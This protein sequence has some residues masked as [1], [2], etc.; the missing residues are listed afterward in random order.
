[1]SASKHTIAIAGENA[2]IIYFGDKPSAET[3]AQIAQAAEQLKMAL[4]KLLVD[5]VPSYGSL[6]V[7]YQP[8]KTDHYYVRNLIRQAL[9]KLSTEAEHNQG[10]T[11]RPACLLQHR[12]WPRFAVPCR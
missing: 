3:A 10:A 8:L 4:G 9:Q 7:T 12:V 2:L 6:L 5:L 11:V 1:M